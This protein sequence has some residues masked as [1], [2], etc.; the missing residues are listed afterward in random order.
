MTNHTELSSLSGQ[1]AILFKRLQ[2]Y[3]SYNYIM[4][5]LLSSA[6]T[7]CPDNDL[8]T[9][10][11]IFIKLYHKVLSHKKNIVFFCYFN[12]LGI[13]DQK[14]GK[15]HVF[16]WCRNNNLTICEWTL[17]NC[18]SRCNTTKGSLRLNLE[19][20]TWTDKEW[21]NRNKHF[22]VQISNWVKVNESFEICQR[23]HT[24]K[25]RLGIFAVA[26]IEENGLLVSDIYSKSKFRTLSGLNGESI[27]APTI[28]DST[29]AVESSPPNEEFCFII[30]I[31]CLI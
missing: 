1:N 20:V 14:R 9:V 5:S 26:L 22:P 10:V 17:C 27:L 24:P 13:K 29:S 15:K 25:G 31:Y 6:Y 8:H 4:L 12:H 30:K 18:N 23:W 3:R 21:G 28:L 2:K 16:S 11:Y 19:V 7:S